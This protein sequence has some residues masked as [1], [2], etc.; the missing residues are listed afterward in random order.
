MYCALESK[1][2]AQVPNKTIILLDIFQHA[3]IRCLDT[4]NHFEKPCE[5][6]KNIKTCSCLDAF[7]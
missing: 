5:K 3:K 6:P 4:Y 7:K 1:R 2:A